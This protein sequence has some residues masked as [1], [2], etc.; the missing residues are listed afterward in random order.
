MILDVP[1]DTAV[2]KPPA[3]TVATAAFDDCHV[4]F[5]VTFCA[6]P[7]ASEAMAESWPV[8]PADKNGAPETLTDVTLTAGG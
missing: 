7:P 3:D 1:G 6:V 5:G 8:D 2:T 4:A